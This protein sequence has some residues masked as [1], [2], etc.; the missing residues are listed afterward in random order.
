MRPVPLEPDPTAELLIL[1]GGIHRGARAFDVFAD[2]PVPIVY[3]M[4]NR[5]AHGSTLEQTIEDLRAA[6]TDRMRFLERVSFV[7]QGV[8]FVGTTLW[9]DFELNAPIHP[10]DAAIKPSVMRTHSQIFV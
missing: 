5:E 6:S 3:V 1:A 8:R 7:F 10:R 2:W 4:G 9:T